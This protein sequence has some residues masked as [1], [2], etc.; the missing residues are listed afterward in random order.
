MATL[1]AVSLSAVPVAAQNPM[2]PQRDALMPQFPEPARVT[3]E[4]QAR[5]RAIQQQPKAKQARAAG[6]TEMLL[7]SAVVKNADGTTI[8]R[9]KFAYDHWGNRILQEGYRWDSENNKWISSSKY[10]Y[11]FDANGNQTLYEEYW[12]DSNKNSWVGYDFKRVSVYDANGNRILSEDYRWDSDKNE[13][14]VFS[15]SVST[16]DGNQTSYSYHWDSEKNEWKPSYKSVSV[17]DYCCPIKI[18]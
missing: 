8:Y 2:P 15:M 7:D 1:F 3:P 9:V 12:W 5:G 16:Y 17:Y 18:F 6:S 4:M 14:G 13:W 10:V 11:A